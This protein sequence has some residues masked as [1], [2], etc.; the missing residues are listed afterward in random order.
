VRSSQRGF[1]RRRSTDSCD[2][3]RSGHRDIGIEPSVPPARGPSYFYGTLP[4]MV[5]ISAAAHT[6]DLTLLFD[7]L[8]IVAFGVAIW[9]AVSARW[10][11]ALV[12]ALIAILILVYAG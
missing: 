11:A 5:P 8:A 12:T 6:A 9:L 7:V 4:C 3:P 10:I 2:G 1:Y